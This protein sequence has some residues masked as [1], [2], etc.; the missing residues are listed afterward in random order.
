M[1]IFVFLHVLVMFVAVAAAY[2]PALMMLTLNRRRDT[3]ALR[4]VM[5]ATLDLGRLVGPLFGLGIALGV[6]AIFLHNFDPLAGW[7][8]IAYVLVTISALMLIF[9]TTPWL[10]RVAAAAEA[11]PDDR[12]SPE[13]VALLNSPRNRLL[14]LVDALVIVA[15]IADMVLKPLPGRIF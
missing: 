6:I 4:G 12:Y 15:L 3:V 1:P 10:K 8:V 2:G 11:S 13:L 9:V 14:L 5:K 7:L